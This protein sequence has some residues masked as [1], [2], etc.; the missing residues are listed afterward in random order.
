M[1][2]S[3]RDRKFRIVNVVD[4]VTVDLIQ[5]LRYIIHTTFQ[6]VVGNAVKQINHRRYRHHQ[7]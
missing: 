3:L 6:Y 2:K 7:L 1:F 4:D 5:L